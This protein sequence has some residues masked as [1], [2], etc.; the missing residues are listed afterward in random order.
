[1]TRATFCPQKDFFLQH[2]VKQVAMSQGNMGCPHEEGEDFPH[3]EDCPFC[4]FWKGKQGAGRKK[5]EYGGPLTWRWLGMTSERGEVPMFTIRLLVDDGDS[6]DVDSTIEMLAARFPG[7]RVAAADSFE[8]ERERLVQ[9][10]DEMSQEGQPIRRPDMIL[11]SL[12]NRRAALGPGKDV[13]LPIDDDNVLVGHV[14]AKDI[15]LSCASVVALRSIESLTAFLRS[16]GK[17][18][19]WVS[20]RNDSCT[21]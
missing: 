14:L 1:M 10:M 12:A 19:V 6:L 11:A 21:K 3:V 13:L 18:K 17:G 15:V 5:R 4:P 9:L 8:A 16:L 7:T 20:H 2:G